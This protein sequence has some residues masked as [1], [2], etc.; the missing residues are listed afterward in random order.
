MS[1]QINKNPPIQPGSVSFSGFHMLLAKSLKHQA[2]E[3]FA[4]YA[5][6]RKNHGEM[7]EM[8]DS[9]EERRIVLILLTSSLIEAIVN[10]Y[11]SLKLPAF[12]FLDL[13][14]RPLLHKLAEVP[15]QFLPAYDFPQAGDL[16]Q[17]L[18]TLVE[19]R[20]WIVHMKPE[21]ERAGQRIHQGNFPRFGR[22][23]HDVILGWLALP[24]KL[25]EHLSKY[26]ASVE[27]RHLELSLHFGS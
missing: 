9:I 18:E 27:F 21:L 3:Y 2:K 24:L 26:D 22:S 25:V 20:N 17:S 15:R 8:M 5:K 12:Q 4:Y 14:R 1:E 19:R 6:N 13:E 16:Y 7:V 10:L 23:D 11:L